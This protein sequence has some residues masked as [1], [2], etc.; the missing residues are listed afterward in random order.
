[1]LDIQTNAPGTLPT[2]RRVYAIGDIHGCGTQ[3][4]ALHEAIAADL[5]ARPIAEPVLVHLGDYVDRGPDVAGVLEKLAAGPPIAGVA[6]VNLLG[7]HER[8]M[9]DALLG[10][11]AAAT[12]WLYTGGR[13]SLASYGID[14]E[15]DARE[16][17]TERVPEA[18]VDFLQ[19]LTLM[20]REGDYVFVHAGIRP[21]VE[22]EA[23]EKQ[24]LLSIRH[25]FLY[26]ESDFGVVV[27]HGH[28][29][30]HTRAPVIKPNR[31]GIDTGAVY[32]GRLTCVVLEADT[33]GFLYA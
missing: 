31:I 32:G 20:H 10:D 4:A 27:V 8:T 1:M 25:T 30:T 12:D 24:D 22:L 6:T 7:N 29:P 15:A 19:N 16:I 11:R 21:G 5:R 33:V 14:P 2:G 23:Q 18:H 13:E 9:L 28:T 3:L 26:S 17:W